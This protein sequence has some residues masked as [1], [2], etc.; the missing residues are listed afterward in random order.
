MTGR[1]LSKEL[2]AGAV[3]EDSVALRPAGWYEDNQVELILGRRAVG[4]DAAARRL[5]LDDGTALG[6]EKLLIAT[7]S[8]AR[9]LPDLEGWPNVHY[10]RTLADARRLRAA[11][12]PGRE[13]GRGRRRVHRPGGGG[14]RPAG[15]ASR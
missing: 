8:R 12:R 9:R 14:D 13:P 5:E 3:D 10:L 11:L 6:Y 2:L 15:W 4:L 7:G 1:P